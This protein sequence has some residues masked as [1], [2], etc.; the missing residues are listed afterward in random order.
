MPDQL[1]QKK[2]ECC[3]CEAC[4]NACPKGIIEMEN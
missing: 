1:Y 3:G 4:M 2:N